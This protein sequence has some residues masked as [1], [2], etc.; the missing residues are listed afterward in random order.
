MAS[1]TPRLGWGMGM[2]LRAD[3]VRFAYGDGRPVLRDACLELR[4]GLVT[5]LFGPNG[6]GKSTLL[7]CLNGS[8]SPS[9]GTVLLDERSVVSMT[10]RDIAQRIAVVPQDTPAEAL[11]F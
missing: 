8:L 9:S 2:I 7:R 1:A 11:P 4:A 3:D 5:G 6:S 10:R